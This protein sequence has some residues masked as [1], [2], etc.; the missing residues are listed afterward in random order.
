MKSHRTSKLAIAL[1]V[2]GVIIVLFTHGIA[3]LVLVPAA[4]ILA[5]SVILIW[6][7]LAHR[8]SDEAKETVSGEPSSDDSSP[9]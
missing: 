4:L 2:L 1:G 6:A 9:R 5:P 8:D 7:S 3:L